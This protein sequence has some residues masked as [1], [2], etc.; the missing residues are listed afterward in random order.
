MLRT[1][2]DSPGLKII[3]FFLDNPSDYSKSE[4]IKA[5][6]ISKTTFYKIWPDLVAFGILKKTRSYGKAQLFTLNRVN[7]VVKKLIAL[8]WSLGKQA[9]EKAA[10][11][12][13]V[14]NKK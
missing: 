11:K 9:A 3:D 10:V 8:D 14:P 2:G 5:I 12:V 13:A 1:L 7:P 6:G 4:I